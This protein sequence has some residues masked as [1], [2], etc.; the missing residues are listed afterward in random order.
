MRWRFERSTSTEEHGLTFYCGAGFLIV[1]SLA[2]AQP[3]REHF[4]NATVLY[5]WASNSRG[6]KLRTFITRPNGSARKVPAIFFVGWLSCDSVEYPK[7]ETD[8]FGAFIRRIIEQS[9][10]ATVRMDKPGVGESQGTRCEQADFQSELEGYQSA[11]DAMSRYEFIDMGRVFVVGMS[12]GGGVAPF[13]ARQRPVRGYV[14]AVSW[15]RTWYEHMLEMERRRLTADKKPPAEIHQAM[16]AFAQFYDDYLNRGMTPGQILE[17]HPE[18]KS[19]W[20]DAPDGQYGRPAAFYQQLQ[21]LN[22]G[23]AWAE[24]TAP[25]LV[26]AGSGDDVMS[27]AD[28]LGIVENVNAAHPGLARYVE[29]ERMT[30][31]L[32]V[33]RKFHAELVPMVLNWLNAQLR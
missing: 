12:N 6:D 4:D 17:R 22:L 5:D 9:R 16:Q 33:A 13:V 32:A 2:C 25:V 26:I 21:A 14:A 7:G 24:V 20:Y 18:W 8:G 1:A 30:H 23:R 10:F 19:L 11:F 27:R 15:G 3:A 28:N 29:I 31:G